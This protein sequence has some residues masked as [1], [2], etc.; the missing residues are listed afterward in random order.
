MPRTRRSTSPGSG[1]RR[2]RRRFPIVAELRYRQL[3]VGGQAG[4]GK[5]INISSS[6]LLFAGDHRCEAGQRLEISISWPVKLNNNCG[7]RLVSRAKV[8]RSDANGMAVIFDRHEFRTCPSD[9]RQL[10]LRQTGQPGNLS[11]VSAALLKSTGALQWR[12]AFSRR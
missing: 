2:D 11:D 10:S 7:L 6:G 12:E 5:T 1:D 3:R 4:A 9:A 8:L